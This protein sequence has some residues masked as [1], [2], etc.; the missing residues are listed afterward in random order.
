MIH[1]LEILIFN[2]NSELNKW[3]QF[4]VAYVI[5]IVG[6]AAVIIGGVWTVYKYFNEK[7]REFYQEVLNNVY[8][9]LF[10]ELVKNEYS[11]KI[12]RMQG[13]KEAKCSVKEVPFINWERNKTTTTIGVGGT[14]I[15]STNSSI[16]NFDD[17][18]KEIYNN[19]EKLKYTPRDLVALLKSYFFLKEINPPDEEKY[20]MS[21]QIKIR[22]NIIVGY[23]KY[24]KKLG[25][26][27]VTINKFCYSIGG[28]IFF[29]DLRSLFR[30]DV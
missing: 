6:C 25:L 9:P 10:G 13:K 11:R 29:V 8:G 27:D 22:K 19:E 24:R 23:K 12:I 21:L 16:Y 20:I 7:Q 30:C 14:K 18:L 3:L 2:Q 26:R 15:K 5:P 1:N 28:H 17:L 4:I